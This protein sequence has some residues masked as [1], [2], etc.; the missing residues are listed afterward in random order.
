MEKA[1]TFPT[2]GVELKYLLVVSDYAR[3]L[4]VY[5]SLSFISFPRTELLREKYLAHHEPNTKIVPPIIT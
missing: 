4:F 3:L 2:D 5:F 1:M